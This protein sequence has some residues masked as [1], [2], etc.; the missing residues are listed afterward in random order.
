MQSSRRVQSTCKTLCTLA[1][2]QQGSMIVE[3]GL[4]AP[5]LITL[6]FGIMEAG[7]VLWT[8]NALHYSVQEAAR[9]ATVDT[10]TCGTPTQIKAF[11]AARSGASLDPSVFS[12]TVV[13]CGNQV[14]ANYPVRLNIPFAQQSLT[15]TAQ[16]CF[17]T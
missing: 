13:A 2:D 6:L 12:A 8:L 17:P 7:R 10:T 5:V 15:L 11:A 9:C 4:I 16:S 3:F 14:T 1:G